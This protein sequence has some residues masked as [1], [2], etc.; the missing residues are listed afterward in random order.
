M[1]TIEDLKRTSLALWV[2]LLLPIGCG[3]GG[4]AQSCPP[5]GVG[6]Y[7][8]PATGYQCV[9]ASGGCASDPT[10]CGSNAFCQ[11]SECK[12]LAGFVDCNTNLGQGGGDGC[13]CRSCDGTACAATC[14][15]AVR[16]SCG[17]DDEAYCANGTC[18][19]CPTGTYNC[20][21]VVTCEAKQKCCDPS[22]TDACDDKGQY[23][24]QGVCTPCP[25]GTYNCD[26][27]ETCESSQRCCV[28]GSQNAC[29]GNTSRFCDA[30][31]Q[32]CV[33]CAPGMFNCDNNGICESN[34]STCG[35]PPSHCEQWTSWT[36]FLSANMGCESTCAES[37]TDIRTVT[38]GPDGTCACTTGPPATTSACQQASPATS[39]CDICQQAF[40]QGCCS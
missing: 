3:G 16:R 32:T 27:E 34:D 9:P 15:P 28:A 26:G 14:D 20:D 18:M 35:P 19:P 17:D 6:S 31:T 38:C 29:L 7:C 23:C 36:C 11:A 22:T 5:C 12:C 37:A 40:A 25:T 21:G 10:R 30:V 24:D 4:D 39:P 8:T 2:T 13:E 1:T 33:P